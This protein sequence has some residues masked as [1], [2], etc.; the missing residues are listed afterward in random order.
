MLPAC[1]YNYL[2]GGAVVRSRKHHHGRAWVDW[3]QQRLQH[4]LQADEMVRQLSERQALAGQ[5][6][7]QEGSAHFVVNAP[8]YD[9]PL[10]HTLWGRKGE[11]CNFSTLII[12]I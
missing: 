11:H 6:H 4:V 2:H 5:C 1:F 3:D 12:N 8:K 7:A 10:I 9:A